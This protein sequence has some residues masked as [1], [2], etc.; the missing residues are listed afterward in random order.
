MPLDMVL[1]R[2]FDQ[3]LFARR[4]AAGAGAARARLLRAFSC[5]VG[6]LQLFLE[7]RVSPAKSKA[8]GSPHDTATSVI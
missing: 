4:A 6:L 5:T 7:E 1:R 2:L 8:T 3:L